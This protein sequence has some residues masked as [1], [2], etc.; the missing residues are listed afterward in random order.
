MKKTTACLAGLLLGSLIAVPCTSEPTRDNARAS[1]TSGTGNPQE[2]VTERAR[3]EWALG[4]AA[5]L[6][7]RNHDDHTLLG[8]CP[9]SESD[10]AAKKRLLSDSWGIDSREKL[11]ETLKWIEDAGH[12]AQFEALRGLIAPLTER[13]F[14]TLLERERDPGVCNKL[15]M[16]R[17]YSGPLGRKS[18]YGWDYSRAICLCRWAYVAGYLEEKEAWERIMP[19]ALLLQETFDSWEDLG[20]NY[21]IGRQ[22]WSLQETEKSGWRCEDA[23]QR[24]LDMRSSPWNRYPWAVRLK[25]SEDGGTPRPPQKEEPKDRKQKMNR[26]AAGEGHGRENSQMV[27]TRSSGS[28][29]PNGGLLV[30]LMMAVQAADSQPTATASGRK[31][32]VPDDYATIEAAVGAANPGDTVFLKTGTYHEAIDLKSGIKLVGEQ[33]DNVIVQFGDSRSVITVRDCTDVSISGLTIRHMTTSRGPGRN[34]G[35]VVNK[36]RAVLSQCRVAE[37]AGSGVEIANQADVTINSCVVESSG[38]RGIEIKNS[39]AVIH[40]CEVARNPVLG[41]VLIGPQTAATVR[42]CRISE[43]RFAGLGVW[44]GATGRAEEN[45]IQGNEV[46]IEVR[47]AG[48]DAVLFKNHCHG[49]KRAGIQI[50]A[51]AKARAEQNLCEE[52]TGRGILVHGRNTMAILEKNRC[53]KNGEQ[54]ILLYAQGGGVLTANECAENKKE[55]IYVNTPAGEI[56]IEQNYC[57]DN[58]EAGIAVCAAGGGVIAQNHCQSNRCFGIYVRKTTSLVTARTNQCVWNQEDGIA[59]GEETQST[60]QDNICSQNGGCGI[61]FSRGARGLAQANACEGNRF[62]GISVQ[63]PNTV[64]TLRKNTCGAN[65]DSGILFLNVVDSKAEGNLCRENL[66]SGIGVRGEKAGPTLSINRCNNNGAWGIISWAGADPN[67]AADNETLDNWKGGI[68]H[69]PPRPEE[70]AMAWQL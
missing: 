67:V 2:P 46:G 56:K 21:L 36:S 39:R 38:A 31:I 23:F 24:L 65:N 50:H 19:M 12:R 25:E 30:S 34:A 68:K 44:L 51:G 13:E 32:V 62:P 1:V 27:G 45:D 61:M 48:A 16:V 8:G 10:K 52:N 20:R 6:T 9:L 57:R 70:T 37:A 5:V 17:R 14:Q 54:G 18:L 35:V 7:E 29:W 55:G 41:I 11:L 60:V 53:L 58:Q 4:C 40:A 33:R 42:Y 59:F 47:D 28:W 15:R 26:I 49:N 3:Q 64:V 63:D 22:F 43:S 66:W 69:R